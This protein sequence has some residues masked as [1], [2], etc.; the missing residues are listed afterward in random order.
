MRIEIE[1]DGSHEGT[2]VKINGQPQPQL[3]E[4]EFFVSGL[5]NR[6]PTLRMTRGSEAEPR[7]P[8]FHGNYFGND[9]ERYDELFPVGGAGAAR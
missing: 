9:F 7:K 1:T 5:R 8:V 4:L 6:K 2:A 3:L